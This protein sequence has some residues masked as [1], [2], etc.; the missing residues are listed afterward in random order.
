MRFFQ[1]NLLR[2]I[3]GK[4]IRNFARSIVGIVLIITVILCFYGLVFGDYGLL[5]ILHLRN[6]QRKLCREIEILRIKEKLLEDYKFR[7]EKDEFLIEKLAR[8]RA[9]LCKPGEIV[10]VFKEVVPST[11]D[12]T[13]QG[14][15]K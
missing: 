2:Y 10:F 9:G 4:S 13:S 5:Q 8:E 3:G 6:E 12:K 11:A 14:L 15:D 1:L 7:L